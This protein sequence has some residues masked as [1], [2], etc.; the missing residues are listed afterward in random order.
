MKNVTS[1]KNGTET[2]ACEYL[3]FI[4]RVKHVPFIRFGRHLNKIFEE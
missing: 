4:N 1:E 3:I 2:V